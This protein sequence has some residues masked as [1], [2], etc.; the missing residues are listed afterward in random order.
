MPVMAT[1]TTRT[2]ERRVAAE[3]PARSICDISQPPKMSPCGL[4]SVGI[5]IA[6]SVGLVSGGADGGLTGSIGKF[7]FLCA[8]KHLTSTYVGVCL[9]PWH[10]LRHR[11][12][13][14]VE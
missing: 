11:K 1:V 12:A 4:V 10:G 9:Y 6:Q 7:E 13:H 5:A 2:F 8:R 14:V 3:L